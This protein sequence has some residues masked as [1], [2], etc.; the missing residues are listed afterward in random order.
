MVWMVLEVQICCHCWFTFFLWSVGLHT[1]KPGW[2]NRLKDKE[3]RWINNHQKYNVL[4][5]SGK[6]HRREIDVSTK[7]TNRNNSN[8]SHS[9][10]HNSYQ[11]S[12]TSDRN[13]RPLSATRDGD[14]LLEEQEDNQDADGRSSSSRCLDNSVDKNQLIMLGMY[15]LDTDQERIYNEFVNMISKFD[16]FDMVRLLLCWIVCSSKWF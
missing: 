15:C 12:Y 11:P 14:D 9:S 5:D 7:T 6:P 8:N 3:G 4:T 2:E 13:A 16:S 1:T 10:S